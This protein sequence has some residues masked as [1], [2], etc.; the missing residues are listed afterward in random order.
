MTISPTADT[1]EVVLE[2]RSIGSVSWSMSEKPLVN[3]SIEPC[4]M[5]L[6]IEWTAALGGEFHPNPNS[7]APR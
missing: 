3:V 2:G 7:E 1:A 4:G 5:P 6:V